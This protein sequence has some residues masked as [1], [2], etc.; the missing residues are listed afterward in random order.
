MRPS[1]D[2]YF[3]RITQEVAQRST[4]LRRQVGAILVK[5]K[6][7]LA[8]GYNGAPTGLPHC[9]E[10]GCLRERLGIPSGEQAELCRGLHAEQNAIIQAAVHG[11]Q[12]RGS[13]LYSTT[14]PCI[15]CAKMLINAGVVRIVYQG[16]Y[17]DELARQM[18]DEA[19]L[20]IVRWEKP[21][22]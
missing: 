16:P 17:P 4:C 2:E 10:V 12:I 22:A 8:T 20:E 1:W 14:Q 21:G 19:G 3:M 5:D 15:L 11:V 13:T 9:E 6:H 7:I 18:M